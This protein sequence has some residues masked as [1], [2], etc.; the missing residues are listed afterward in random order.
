MGNCVV[1]RECTFQLSEGSTKF[2]RSTVS[3]GLING[4]LAGLVWMFV[5]AAIGMVTIV[6]SLAEMASM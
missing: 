5:V 4:G 2:S 6:F 3:Y 1:V